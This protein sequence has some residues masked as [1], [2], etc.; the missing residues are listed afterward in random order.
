M[1]GDFDDL[2]YI[3]DNT[4][5]V[6]MNNLHFF[7]DQIQDPPQWKQHQAF[8]KMLS[9]LLMPMIHL[10]LI[11]VIIE[12]TPEINMFINEFIC[13]EYGGYINLLKLTTH[14]LSNASFSF[15]LNDNNCKFHSCYAFK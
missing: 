5:K 2:S 6:T 11:W 3:N 8:L 15:D 14:I 12:I 10:F 1:D 9:G 13:D 7:Y 4:A